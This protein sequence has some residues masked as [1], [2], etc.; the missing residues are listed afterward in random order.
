[1]SQ[2]ES[3]RVIEAL[4]SGIPSRIVGQY[5]TGT[6]EKLLSSINDNI[7]SATEGS[8]SG[9][10]I[11]GKYGE[12]KTHLLNTVFSAAGNKNLVVSILPL[13][14]E[15]PFDKLPVI[16]Q[17]LMANTYLPNREQPGFLHEFED[18]MQDS[19]FAADLILFASTSLSCNKLSFLLKNHTKEKDAEE[20]HKL[21]TD[22]LG[23]FISNPELKKRYRLLFKETL[24]FNENFAKTKHILDYFEFMSYLFL[25]LGYDGWVILFDEAELIGRM[26]KNPRLKAYQNMNLFL[27][28]AKTLHSTFTLFAFTSS[29]T[30][31]VIESKH[32]FENLEAVYPEGNP[33]IKSSLNA[34]LKAPQLQPLNNQEIRKVIDTI[35]Q[36]YADAYNWT[37]EVSSEV[38]QKQTDSSGFLLRTKLRTCIEILDQLYQYGEYG[39]IHTGQLSEEAYEEDIPDLN[40]ESVE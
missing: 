1:M 37:P 19:R 38:I 26:S 24:K 39:T 22:L 16:Y 23:D 2:F 30:E 15:T 25:K 35:I 4:R 5:F 11:T 29:Y 28:P 7:Q 36:I 3:R 8:S 9:M 6:R 27:N 14:K 31:D 12:G 20:I 34:I 13:S 17:K 21:Q 32:D 40:Q 33:A 10:I 18:K